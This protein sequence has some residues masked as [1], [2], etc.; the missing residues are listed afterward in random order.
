MRLKQYITEFNKE[1]EQHFKDRKE[2]RDVW[3]P[4]IKKECQKWLK[5]T[6][7]HPLWRGYSGSKDL[8]VKKVRQN[9]KPKDMDKTTSEL[10]DKL[11][12]KKFGWKPRSQGMFCIPEWSM[13]QTYGKP[14]I[15]FVPGNFKYIWSD[16]IQDLYGRI[17]RIQDTA[18]Y[19]ISEGR[20]QELVDKYT[21]KNL[22][23]IFYVGFWPE[24]MVKCN[25]YYFVSKQIIEWEYGNV[26]EFM[27][28]LR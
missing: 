12:Q 17:R 22:K 18:E 25:K 14:G 24:V 9:R 6:D 4:K 3:V 16:D 5:E 7:Y 13:A 21:D 27:E 20:L 26:P 10:L 23:K 8:D 1:V 28:N 11:F 2:L 15:V 19:P